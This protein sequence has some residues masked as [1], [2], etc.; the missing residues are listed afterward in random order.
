MV[1]VLTLFVLGIIIF[2]H[3]LGHY[4]AAK[5]VGIYIETFSIGFGPKILSFRFWDTE[6]VLAAIPFGGY[7]KMKGDNPE[8]STFSHD[9]FLGKS[10]P[11]RIF[12]V[13]SGPLMNLILGFTIFFAAYNI[14][15]FTSLPGNKVWQI[16]KESIA[17]QAGF[18][19][20]DEILS[21]DG[22]PFKYWDDFFKNIIKPGE[23]VVTVIR[24]NSLT[25]LK[26]VYKDSLKLGIVPYIPPVVGAVRKGGPAYKAGL[27]PGDSVISINGIQVRSWN[28]MVKIIKSHPGEPIKIS[29]VRNG[30]TLTFTVVPEPKVIENGK[31]VGL[32]G[33]MSPYVRV[34]VPVGQALE[35]AV[36]R[37]VSS[38]F[39]IFDIL[40]KLVVRKV[41]IRQIGGPVMIG[42]V[43]G[44]SYNYGL[45]TLLIVVALISINLFVINIIPFPALDGWYAIL[46]IIEGI[47]KKPVPLKT[48]ATLQRLGFVF[49]IAFMLLITFFDLTRVF[50][51]K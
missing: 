26:V 40:G 34:R 20:G 21:V 24:G 16:E 38:A 27:Q 36:D 31:K 10:V 39:L 13:L 51:G 12:V 5:A 7:V 37:T 3:E 19:P 41:S 4:L 30:K 44:E 49:L 47:I 45:Y 28:D 46:F 22:K 9:E 2:V 50:G 6:W 18:E 11:Q 48:Q 25:E 35:I 43:I 29:V 33:V 23:H 42:K 1:I 32:I 17:A 14:V 8:E 15:G